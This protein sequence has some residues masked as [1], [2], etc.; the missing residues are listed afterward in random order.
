MRHHIS[1]GKSQYT[2]DITK[3]WCLTQNL[4]AL[5]SRTKRPHFFVTQ[6]W[7]KI[8]SWGTIESPAFYELALGPP[9]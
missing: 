1:W 8:Q 3:H 5:Q 7:S 4:D 9:V 6:L 2:E